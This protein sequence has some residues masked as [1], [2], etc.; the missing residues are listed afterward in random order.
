MSEVYSPSSPLVPI[1]QWLPNESL[2]SLGSRNHVF[3]CNTLPAQTCERLFGSQRQGTQHDLPTNVR[4]LADRTEGALGTAIEIVR[5]HTILPFFAPFQSP[6]RIHAAEQT[7]LGSHLGSLKYQLGL[8]TGRFGAQH[9]LRACTSCM[10]EGIEKLGIA[11]WHLDH[12]YP[13]VLVCTRHREILRESVHKRL[14]AGRFSWCL[15]ALQQLVTRNELIPSDL[16]PLL[17]MADA[18]TRLASLGFSQFFDSSRLR[19]VYASAIQPSSDIHDRVVRVPL[20]ASQSFARFATQFKSFW[21]FQALPS[22]EHQAQRY[23]HYL[24]L[25]PRSFRHPLRHLAAITWMFDTFDDFLLAYSS[26]EQAIPPEKLQPSAPA[27]TKT[28][29]DKPCPAS[30]GP[31]RPKTLKPSVRKQALT[32][33]SWGTDK[34]SVCQ[35]IGI[36]VSTVNKLLRAEPTVNE[37]WK[38]AFRA[39]ECARYRALWSKCAKDHPGESTQQL[40]R[41]IPSIYAWIY[42]NDRTWLTEQTSQLPSGRQGN[43]SKVD[44]DRRDR[45]LENLV[46]ERIR[47]F[48]DQNSEQTLDRGQV[49]L[50]VPELPSCLRKRAQYPLTWRYLQGILRI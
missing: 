31:L 21:P 10:A 27:I 24:L 5:Q 47:T 32:L 3:L 8:I 17:R 35:R 42:R 43:H 45:D 6:T 15:P 19:Q 26:S 25:P 22:D 30:F 40:R 46:R 7:M 34:N 44:W 12:Q 13:G 36:T 14:W 20:A 33:L 48:F 49:Y 38:V 29:A 39:R 18:C 50:L 1:R 23:L 11:Y 2:F 16:S 41:L 4:I 28:Q 37:A 9:P